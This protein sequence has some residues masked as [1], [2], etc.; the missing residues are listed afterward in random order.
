[1]ILPKHSISSFS[2]W[3]PTKCWWLPRRVIHWR[4]RKYIAAFSSETPFSR[5]WGH[6]KKIVFLVIK[7]CHQDE[8]IDNS[9]WCP[10]TKNTLIGYVVKINLYVFI[11]FKLSVTAPSV[12][13]QDAKCLPSI[14]SCKSKDFQRKKDLLCFNTY[15]KYTEYSISEISTKSGDCII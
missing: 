11:T 10:K 7:A 15:K 12:S 8:G 3:G 6:F 9:V 5:K 14:F 2:L 4:K 13:L 1:M